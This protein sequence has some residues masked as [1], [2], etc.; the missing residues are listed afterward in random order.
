MKFTYIDINRASSPVGWLVRWELRKER[1]RAHC[2]WLGGS[3]S[4][5]SATVMIGIE[6]TFDGR[7]WNGTRFP[8]LEGKEK[9]VKRSK[10]ES[11]ANKKWLETHEV[12]PRQGRRFRREVQYF[13]PQ[14]QIL[15]LATCYQW[16]IKHGGGIALNI[17]MQKQ[18]SLCVESRADLGKYT[19]A[20]G[21][22][23]V[24]CCPNFFL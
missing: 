5:Q 15:T 14:R 17:C 10:Y 3:A 22:G 4:S 1:Q 16:R 20:A 19:W 21:H 24:R 7:C 8:C 9:D 2:E 23:M 12:M 18:S 13:G 11:W 6:W